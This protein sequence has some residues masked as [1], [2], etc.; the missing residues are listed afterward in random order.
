MRSSVVVTIVSSSSSPER[1][2]RRSSQRRASGCGNF[3]AAPKPPH[4]GVER[5]P[6]GRFGFLHRRVVQVERATAGRFAVSSGGCRG[7][8]ADSPQFAP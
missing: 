5:P 1:R 6:Q 7:A 3:G 8:R 4:C 2:Q